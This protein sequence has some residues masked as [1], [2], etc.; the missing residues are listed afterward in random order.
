MATKIAFWLL[1]VA[2]GVAADVAAQPSR[3]G[4]KVTEGR[5]TTSDGVQIFF[6]KVGHGKDVVVY[7]H[8]GPG[9]NF[10]GQEDYVEPLARGRTLIFY[11]QRGSG[12]SEIVTDPK[13][14]TASHHVQDLEDVRKHFGAERLSILG[15]SWG[16]ALAALYA[17]RHPKRVRRIV[18]M[19]PISPRRELLDARIVKLNSLRTPQEN[20]RRRELQQRLTTAPDSDVVTICR[21]F[22]NSTFFLYFVDPTP[23]KLAHAARRCDIP[24]AA[25]RNRPVVEAAVFRSLGTWDLRP[26]LQKLSMP[27]L[28]MEGDRTN[29]P[30]EATR[31]FAATL[32]NSRLILVRDAGHEF[33]VD[34]PRAFE[35]AVE[36]FLQGRF[37]A[38]AKKVDQRGSD[39]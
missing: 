2:L 23:D 3:T 9:S 4:R 35:S 14:L 17:D 27:T 22:S 31:E 25:I 18:F 26:V 20:S 28:V 12:L 5:L 39:K 7:L 13:L 16:S 29:V 6:R 1:L 19:S 36:T 32:P 38:G 15:L 11:D 10:R 24:P 37:P 34:Q 30:L 33:F 21:E 8:G